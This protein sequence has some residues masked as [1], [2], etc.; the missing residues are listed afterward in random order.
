MLFYLDHQNRT[1]L[2]RVQSTTLQARGWTERD[3][4]NLIAHHI[5]RII[6]ED[7]LLVISQER[8]Y[9]EEPD[10]MALDREGRLHIFELKRWQSSPEN[11]LQ[12]LRYGQRF[13]QYEYQ[14]LDHLFRSYRLR[15]G[16]GGT[17]E[18]SEAHRGY[19]ELP[20]PLSRLEFNREQQFIV[21]TDGLDRGTRDAINYWSG[22]GIPVRALPYRVF[23]TRDNT[24]ILDVQPY[25]ARGVDLA[26]IE[27]GLV[28][29]NTNA[30]YMPDAWRD[31]LAQGKASAY[32][33]R[34]TALQGIPRGAPIALYH[35]GVGIITLGRTTDTFRR[36]PVN[37]EPDEEFFVPC[38]FEYT[39]D[40][41][42]E[43]ERAVAARDINAHL[44]GS[45]RFRQTIYT[46]PREAIDFI[47]ARLR[48]ARD[49]G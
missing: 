6:R 18:L 13:G 27:E 7:D 42:A 40:P 46:L 36:A 14:A 29:V 28:V 34:K 20:E 9:Q 48:E 43:P 10:I 25:S 45:H 17:E 23:L 4:E 21:I 22:R 26:D 32:F 38:D 15:V 12:V 31:M 11:L 16:R 47:R 41:V 5:D 30:T 1:N 2:E 24:P 33:G 39:V 37:D 3:L 35:T 8:S 19:F 44:K 49:L